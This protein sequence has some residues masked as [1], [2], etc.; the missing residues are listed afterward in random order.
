MS[1]TQTSA[2]HLLLDEEERA[3]LR[4]VLEHSLVETHG[5]LRRTE[6]PAYQEHVHKQQAILQGLV[7]KVKDLGN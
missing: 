1:A 6:A 3:V 2:Y 5:E 7:K 4:E